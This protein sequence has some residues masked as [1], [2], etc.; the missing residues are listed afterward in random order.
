M[1]ISKLLSIAQVS[2]KL[3]CAGSTVRKLI[4]NGELGASRIGFRTIRIA[5]VDLQAYLNSRA[6]V[7][8]PTALHTESTPGRL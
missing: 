7:S 3:Q 6:N 5:E 1:P 8:V 2:G 4:A